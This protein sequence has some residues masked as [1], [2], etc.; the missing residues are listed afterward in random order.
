[1]D[2]AVDTIW[3]SFAFIENEK[4]VRDVNEICYVQLGCE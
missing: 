1:M 3:S 4:N 2:W